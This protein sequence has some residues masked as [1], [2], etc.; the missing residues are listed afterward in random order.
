ML[1]QCFEVL[2]NAACPIVDLGFGGAFTPT[3]AIKRD[4]SKACFCK[5][6][7]L[8][9]PDLTAAGVGV[10]QNQN[11]LVMSATGIGEP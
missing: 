5:H 8:Y 7:R 11:V 2:G 3:A 10:K 6:Q 9:G 4:H 1:N